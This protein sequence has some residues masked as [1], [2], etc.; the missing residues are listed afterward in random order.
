MKN[1]KNKFGKTLTTLLFGAA[2]LFGA[3]GC[4]NELSDDNSASRSASR[5]ALTSSELI[6]SANTTITI[7]LL[8]VPSINTKLKVWAWAK[9]T[10]EVNYTT[11]D[12]PG[13]L[14]MEA[15]KI[16]EY[17]GYTYKLKVNNSYDLGILFNSSG[18]QTS[19]III[20]KKV[21]A[22][23]VTLYFNW[24]SMAYYTAIEDC[25]GIMS[26]SITALSD[27]SATLSIST[28]LI[29]SI[30]KGAFSVKDG[31]GKAL[32]VSDDSIEVSSNKATVKLASG[33]GNLS[34]VPYT[35]SYKGKNIIATVALSLIEE[36]FGTPASKTTDKLGLELNGS[37]ATFRTWAPIATKAEVLLYADSKAAY[38]SSKTVGYDAPG[39]T[40]QEWGTAPTG[41]AV[42]EM[43][44][45]SSTGIWKVENVNVSG[46]K[47]YK[48]RLTISGVPYYVSDIWHT[49]AGPDSVASQIAT[50]D[51]AETKPANWE[52]SYVNP[53]GSTGAETKKYNDA[54]IYEMHIRDWSRAFVKDSTGK[55]VDI[56]NNLGSD[57]K[58]AKHL[59]DLGVTH[60]QILPMFDYAQINSNKNYNW[61]YNP[62]HYNVPEGRYVTD[63]YTDGTQAV[64]EMRRM[65]QAFHEAGIAVIMD[66]V[67]NHTSGTA[68]GSLYDST[69]PGYFYRQDASGKYSNGSGCGNET[70]SDRAMVGKYFLESLVHWV[71]DYHINGFRFDLM[72]IHDKDFMKKVYDTL[73]GIDKNILVYGEPWGGGTI[74][75]ASAKQSVSAGRGTSGS[76]YGAF[77]DDF[78]DALKGTDGF[79][80]FNRGQIQGTFADSTV[81]SGLKGDVIAKN[82]RNETGITGLAL[83]YAECHDNY[84]LFDKLVY[85]TDSSISG[86]GDWAPKFAALYS[87]VMNSSEK[88]ALIKKENK[89]AAAYVILSQGTPFINGG[90]EFMRT[91]KGS[92]DSYSADKNGGIEWTNTPGEYNIDDVNTI[93]LS[94]KTKFSDVYNVYKGLIALRNEYSAFRG[95]GS[96]DA[97]TLG[98]GVT[99]Y[100]V[101]AS[102]GKFTVLF[103]A[104][105]KDAS[106]KA[107]E[108][109]LVDVE[110]RPKVTG[111]YFGLGFVDVDVDVDAYTIS[112]TVSSTTSIPAKSFVIIKTN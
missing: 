54:V 69:V 84:T 32:V 38:D 106:V 13:D 67:Y 8:G 36:K 39:A 102:D 105:D 50:I 100:T 82:K 95:Y 3:T 9:A 7:N 19:D 58:F 25:I 4:A 51:D 94:L 80:G 71:E 18:G 112:K 27:S 108:G 31:D 41:D 74:G 101:S 109:K 91:K 59:K 64:K 107:V 48:Y 99:K 29:D 30:D 93:D 63:D 21:F 77:E 88:L 92:P 68:E 98:E 89:L 26:A 17:D 76:G 14:E 103:N 110:T 55:F 78:R 24:N 66:V 42:K 83:H 23:D 57:G 15:A 6:A 53:F 87:S 28:S 90:Q 35:I 44:V 104:T 96:A 16:G 40:K 56:A 45:D 5:A 49:I 33:D 47:Y 20:S 70:A 61:G 97:E 34:R 75:L 73:Y 81:V 60:V 10:P 85:S 11:V 22:S 65:I 46:Y 111:N 79:G 37:T 12:W 2:L 86:D 52:A 62:Y 72:G 1:I 43:T